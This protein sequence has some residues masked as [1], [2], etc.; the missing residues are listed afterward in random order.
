VKGEYYAAVVTRAYRKELDRIE[1]G[2]A[3]STTEPYRRELWNV[4]HREFSTGFYFGD[5]DALVPGYSGYRQRFRFLGTVGRRVAP[6]RYALAVKN[7]VEAGESIEFI[8]PN[9][10]Y[11]RDASFALFASDG[12]RVDRLTHHSGGLIEPSVP[13]EPGF[14]VRRAV[15]ADHESPKYA[16]AHEPDA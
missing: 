10:P 15:V 8:G 7:T 5:P 9:V 11:V 3:H 2:E 1:R 6:S 12:S 13:V 16:D 4:S 14:L